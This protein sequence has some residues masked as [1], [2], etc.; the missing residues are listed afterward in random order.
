MK[1]KAPILNPPLVAFEHKRDAYGFPVRPQH[2]QRYR[3][4]ANIYKEEEEERSDR[5]K[6]FLERSQSLH[7]RNGSSAEKRYGSF[8][9]PL[10]L[11]RKLMVT[12]RRPRRR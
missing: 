1:P 9:F 8:H 12:L 2:V 11:K 5:W 10:L 6:D 3:E 4:Y 7:S